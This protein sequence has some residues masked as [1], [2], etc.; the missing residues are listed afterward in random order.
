MQYKTIILELIRQNQPL[1][2]RL[3]AER[4]LLPTMEDLATGLKMRHEQCLE[5]FRQARPN[6]AEISLRSQAFEI[7]VKEFEE[8][9]QSDS[10][11]DEARAPSLAGAMEFIRRHASAK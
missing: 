1:H 4:T 6:Q 2:D 10:Q 8:A 3:K 7:A 9:L 11:A 5:E